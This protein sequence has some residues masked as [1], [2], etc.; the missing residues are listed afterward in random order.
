MFFALAFLLIQPQMTAHI[1]LSAKEIAAV[2]PA[3]EVSSSDTL[4]TEVSL[5]S[6]PISLTSM[7]TDTDAPV[8]PAALA[9]AAAL[10]SAPEPAPI[11]V[12]TATAFLKAAKPGTV[13]VNDLRAEQRRK[14]RLWMALGVADHTAATFDAWT[15]RYAVG[16]YGA[17]ELNP[18]LRPFAGNASLYMAI[19]VGPA[20]MDYVGKKMMYSR[21]PLLRHMWWIPQSAS[22]ASSLFCGAH[23]IA[24]Q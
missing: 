13:S 8:Q 15:T 18:T 12:P 6:I 20:L 22:L 14:D 16:H 3:S 7:P 24:V 4:P 23:N 9:E 21:H 17:R 11:D 1:S 10:P 19:Q 2:Q 5:A